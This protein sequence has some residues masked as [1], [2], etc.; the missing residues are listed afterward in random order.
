MLKT[1]ILT[2]AALLAA[3]LLALFL[4]PPLGWVLLV[5]AVIGVAAVEW[6]A[7]CGLGRAGRGLYALGIVLAIGALAGTAAGLDSW[8]VPLLAAAALFWL[9]VAPLWLREWRRV[10]FAHAWL[11]AGTGI[12]PTAGVAAVRLREDGTGTLLAVLAVVWIADT[13]AYFAGRAFG[14]RKLAPAISPGKTWEG[15]GGALI[16]GAVFAAALAAGSGAESAFAGRWLSIT[17][18]VT[19]LVVVSIVGDLYESALKRRAG[20]KDSGSLLPGHG[21]VLDR[22]DSLLAAL[23]VAALLVHL[24]RRSADAL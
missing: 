21:G 4:L 6:A 13:A 20:A 16:A 24:A 5:A 7:L 8:Q 11:L 14:R 10:P 23:P 19:V 22:V 15:A 9:V 18:A 3:F 2:A 12:L 1:R 17:L